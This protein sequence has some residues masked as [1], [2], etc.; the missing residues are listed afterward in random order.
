M[1]CAARRRR[2]LP[3]LGRVLLPPALLVFRR[4]FRRVSAMVAMIASLSTPVQPTMQYVCN[5]GRAKSTQEIGCSGSAPVQPVCN[6]WSSEINA[7]NCRFAGFRGLSRNGFAGV[8]RV[9]GGKRK[10]REPDHA[11]GVPSRRPRGGADM[12]EHPNACSAR[13]RLGDCGGDVRTMT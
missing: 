9:I 3:A 5:I 10:S 8:P 1:I 2:R 7:R 4:L 11:A 12:Q 13:H 6:I